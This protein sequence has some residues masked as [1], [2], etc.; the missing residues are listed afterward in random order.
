VLYQ[1]GNRVLRRVFGP[2]REKVVGSWR[3]LRNEELHNLYA[4]SN[5]VRLIKYRRMRR[6]MQHAW[7]R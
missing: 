5:I 1:L 6:G 4:S 7:E 3:R 2:K